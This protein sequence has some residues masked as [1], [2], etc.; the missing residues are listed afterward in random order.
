MT[1]MLRLTIVSGPQSRQRGRLKSTE[2][3]SN[4][5][6]QPVDQWRG[7]GCG[8]GFGVCGSGGGVSRNRR[9]QDI[10]NPALA[11]FIEGTTGYTMTNRPFASRMYAVIDARGKVTISI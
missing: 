6:D 3:G 2:L 7:A 4:E 8:S 9:L 11:S 5:G 10:S 1:G